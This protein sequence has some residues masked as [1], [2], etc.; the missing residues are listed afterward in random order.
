[1]GVLELP[2]EVLTQ[3][4]DNLS[5]TDRLSCALTCK[6]WRYP[7]QDALWRNMPIYTYRRLKKII[8]TII[9]SQ[10]VSTP[11][12]LFVKSLRTC[13][14]SYR[15][16]FPDIEF[17]ELFK[18]LPNLKR[19]DLGNRNYREIY[20]EIT[21]SDKVWKTL[22][23]LKV[24][25]S[26][27]TEMLPEKTIFEFINAC[28]MLQK[29]EIH[30][31]G[32]GFYMELSVDDFDNM[33]LNLQ[34]L[35]S[36]KAEIY[37]SCDFL[38]TLDTIPNTTPAFAVTALD[39]NSKQYEN[40]DGEFSRNWNEWNPLWLYYFGYKYPNLRSLRLEATS[41]CGDEIDL[42]Q[43]Q[44]IISL[45]QSNPNA[46]QHLKTFSF[47]CDS[48][49]RIADFVLWELFCALK[50]PLKSLTLDA[51][52][53]NEVDDSNPMDI[54]R[55]LESFSETLKSL[56]LTGFTYNEKDR[57][58]ILE[59]SS[60]YPLLT[61]LC[62][63]SEELSLNLGN[64]FDRCVALKQLKFCGGDLVLNQKTTIEESAQQKQEQYYQHG[65]QILILH[66]CSLA[67]EVFNYLSFRC[68]SLKHMT[69]D[70]VLV[71]GSLCEKTG[72]LLLDMS[73]TF[74]K[75]LKI[76]QLQYSVSNQEMYADYICLTLLSQ[77][78]DTP[79]SKGKS[80]KDKARIGSKYPT[81]EHHD[82]MWLFTYSY[83]TAFQ[84]SALETKE[85]LED[86]VDIALE[87]Y[88]DFQLNKII[89]TLMD[90]NSRVREQQLKY[91]T[92]E[93]HK[94]YGK[95]NFGNIESGPFICGPDD[96]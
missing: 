78:N 22:E 19:L 55:I 35:S 2:Y 42:D 69:L 56:S 48:Y 80:G 36:I 54:N 53:N 47:T 63:S 60:Y 45:F 85:L 44:T 89:S 16:E 4:G 13:T 87:Y 14:S 50:V 82:I 77:L 5:T 51:T 81:V 20:T 6:G 70:T 68:Q 23:S 94:G 18:Y 1:M 17:S 31:R 95:W 28:S 27:D 86:E 40:H 32:L 76:G 25:Y 33:H 37:L 10:D 71:K 79:L 88:Q 46:F 8:E 21:R 59:L 58:S 90:K 9:A 61:N 96:I 73:H 15:S 72:C 91:R 41:I 75:T 29:L 57:Y 12:S 66:K 3:I 64:L 83:R 74:L 38:Y 7:F 65:L 93:L 49:F 34:N 67:A 30:E 26:A 92:Y 24:K 43:R 84:K 11:C 62:I 52:Y 39:I